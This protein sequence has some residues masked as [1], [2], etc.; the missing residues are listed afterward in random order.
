MTYVLPALSRRHRLMILLYVQEPRRSIPSIAKEHGFSPSHAYRVLHSPLGLAYA[1]D[2]EDK[3]IDAS[4][5]ASAILPSLAAFG[6]LIAQGA[7]TGQRPALKR[8]KPATSK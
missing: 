3:I 2:L 6:D 4:I 8:N 5:K 1:M 7:R